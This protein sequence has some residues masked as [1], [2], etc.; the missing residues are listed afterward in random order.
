MIHLCLKACF[1]DDATQGYRNQL[2][3]TKRWDGKVAGLP[4]FFN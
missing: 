3:T 4:E 2:L 1:F